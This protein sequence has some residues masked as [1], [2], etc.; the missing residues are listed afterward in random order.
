[1][2]KSI[3]ISPRIMLGCSFASALLRISKI[4][5]LRMPSYVVSFF[6]VSVKLGI[7]KV[8]RFSVLFLYCFSMIVRICTIKANLWYS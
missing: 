4:E 6:E 5:I 2:I 3:N 7:I 1:M 8:N